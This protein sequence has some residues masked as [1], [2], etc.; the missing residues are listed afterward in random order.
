MELHRP[1]QHPRRHSRQRR[2]GRHIQQPLCSHALNGGTLAAANAG[3]PNLGNFQLRG[4]VTVGGSSS[5]VISADVRVVANE[6]RT[7]TVAPTGDPT[8]IDLLVS[9]KLGHHNGT[10]WGYAI[11]E[12]DGVMKISGINEIGK[13]TVNAGKLILENSGIAGMWNGGLLNNAQTELSVTGSNE[14]SFAQAIQGSGALTKT[15]TG[16]LVLAAANSY[17]GDTTVGAGTLRLG[18]ASLADTSTVSIAADA[19]IDLA[20]SGSDTVR[21]LFINGV[22]QPRGVW[23]ATRD[24]VHFAGTGSLVVTDGM[25]LESSGTWTSTSDGNWSAFGNWQGNTLANGTDKIATFNQA[26][27]VTV[28]LDTTRTLGGLSFSTAN[29]TITGSNALTLDVTTGTPQVSV[30]PGVTATIAAPLAGSDGLSKTGGGTLA[31]SGENTYAGATTVDGGTLAVSVIAGATRH[32]DA[33]RLSLADG[34]N[35]TSWADLTSSVANA[36]VPSGNAT[37]TYLANAGTGTGLGAV[38]FLGN[39]NATDSQALKF[40]RATD[41]RSVLSVFKGSSFL[42]TDYRGP[43]PCTA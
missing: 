1:H 24:G 30:G 22:Q 35:V 42:M 13:L 25:D 36:T 41:V 10:A 43:M 32:F 27:G 28:T 38:N 20:F 16:T 26:T 3:D 6:T 37:P 17:T 15:G 7:F 5:S 19:K 12:G 18:V 23:N 9:G 39:N 14:V 40:A 11:K 2:C 31:L 34:A 33:S 29:T 4:D 21:Q 8:G